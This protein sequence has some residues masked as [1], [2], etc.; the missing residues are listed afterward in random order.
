[1]ILKKF[2]NISSL[3]PMLISFER[4]LNKTGNVRIT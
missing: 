1:M 4:I 3:S 2:A